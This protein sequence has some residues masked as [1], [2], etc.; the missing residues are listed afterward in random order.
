MP[1]DVVVPQG[2]RRPDEMSGKR[3]LKALLPEAAQMSRIA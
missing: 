2:V 1:A 3:G